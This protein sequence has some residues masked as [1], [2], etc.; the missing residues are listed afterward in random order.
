MR[1]WDV[2]PALLC[3]P[4]LLGEHRELHAIWNILTQDKRGYR[5]HSEVRRWE[6]Q[7]RALFER[8]QAQVEEILRRGWNHRSNLD[9][10]L[11]RRGAERLTFVNTLEEQI[12]ILRGK[13][14]ECHV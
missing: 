14:C 10:S 8:H 6:G 4:H 2:D 9:P 13:G 11:A 12:E 5:S 7:L 1:V 3:R